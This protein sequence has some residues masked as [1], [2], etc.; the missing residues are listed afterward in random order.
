LFF[1][2]AMAA[3]ESIRFVESFEPAPPCATAV[4]SFAGSGGLWVSS[5]WHEQQA[6]MAQTNNSL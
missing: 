1:A 5:L 3:V 4:E 6:A 2:E